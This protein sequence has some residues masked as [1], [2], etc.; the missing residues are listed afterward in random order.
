MQQIS[1]MDDFLFDLNGY[2]IL[3]NAV[4]SELLDRLN[5]EYDAL[6]RE[7][8][9]GHWYKGA[10]RRDYTPATGMELHHCIAIG[11]PFEELID[12][13][14]WVN[15]VRHYCGEEN[16]YV[17]G[18]FIDECIAS[19]RV[20]GGHHPVHSG[21][22]RTPLRCLYRFE[23]GEFRCGQ[24]N[25]ILALTDIGPGDG[26]TMVIPGSHKSK[27]RHPQME[28]YSYGGDKTMDSIVG[29]V[30]AYMEKGD[31]LLFSDS[32]MHGGSARTNRGERRITIYRYGPAWGKTRYGYE[33]S[34]ELLGRLTPQRRRI[35]QPRPTIHEGE[36]WLPKE[37]MSIDE[38]D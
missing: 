25:V 23:D 2:L 33:Y 27:M 24:V 35:L 1:P 17:R 11:T 19:V 21:N 15:H 6:P 18:L 36:T 5:A 31:V 3:K 28:E 20:S 22:Y 37:L 9:I 38:S 30:P 34:P 8:P 14:S 4:D 12:H 29:A 26:A 13:P 32:I 7:L 10:Q 16:S